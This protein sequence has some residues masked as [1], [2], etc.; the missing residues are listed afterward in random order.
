MTHTHLHRFFPSTRYTRGYTDSQ[1]QGHIQADTEPVCTAH[2]PHTATHTEAKHP[3]TGGYM[4]RLTNTYA[5]HTWIHTQSPP[6]STQT[7]TGTETHR[8]RHRPPTHT[9][10]HRHQDCLTHISTH[11][12][13]THRTHIPN[14]HPHHSPVSL[15]LGHSPR[16]TDAL[17]PLCLSGACHGGPTLALAGAEA[18]PSGGGGQGRWR[19][20]NRPG[21]SISDPHFPGNALYVGTAAFAMERK[22][23]QKEPVLSWDLG[24]VP[25]GSTWP[26]AALV[27]P[28]GRGCV[29]CGRW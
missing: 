13:N 22:Q 25:Q 20:C 28:R 21:Q 17:C 3:H 9:G 19:N 15:F 14:A 23:V 29:C 8:D 16:G 18:F 4:H 26:S 6:T 12:R 2:I 11:H 5:V 1:A 10:T 24:R 7:H 27:S